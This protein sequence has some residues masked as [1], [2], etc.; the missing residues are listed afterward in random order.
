MTALTMAQGKM[1]ECSGK[2]YFAGAVDIQCSTLIIIDSKLPYL[3]G[4]WL[5]FLQNAFAGSARCREAS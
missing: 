1:I 3:F 2:E 5:K 4:S